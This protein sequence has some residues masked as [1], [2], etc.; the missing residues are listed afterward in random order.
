SGYLYQQYRIR[1]TRQVYRT[2]SQSWHAALS[3]LCQDSR[4]LDDWYL[5]VHYSSLNTRCA[6]LATVIVQEHFIPEHASGIATQMD[7]Y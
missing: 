1:S 6:W 7:L 5:R 4:S 2:Y 3:I